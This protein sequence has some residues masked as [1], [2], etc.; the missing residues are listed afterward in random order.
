MNILMW[1][2]AYDPFS[3]YIPPWYPWNFVVEA[4]PQLLEF[5]FKN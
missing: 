4:I 1:L 3:E 2:I 5:K